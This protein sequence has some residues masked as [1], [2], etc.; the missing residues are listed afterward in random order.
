[1]PRP[2]YRAT[3]ENGL[4]LNLNR[5]VRR[6]FVRP[7]LESPA[8]G[9]RWSSDY[10]G[11]IATGVIR[12]NMSGRDES[13]LR[14]QVGNVDQRF[15][16]VARP[17]HFGGVQWYFVCPYLNRRCTVLWMP[18]GA[19]SFSCRQRYGRSVAYASQFLDPDNRAH[20]GKSKIKAKLCRIGR[21]DPDECDFPPKPKWMRWSTYRRAEDRFDHYEA[22]LDEGVLAA[23]IKL[24]MKF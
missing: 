15:I 10:W 19:R 7:G 24:G 20:R 17:R 16:L 8:V 21:F 1:M 14:I 12:A 23:A 5:L 2:G 22:T 9:I 13:W 18:P 11:E 6:G 4:S 3:L